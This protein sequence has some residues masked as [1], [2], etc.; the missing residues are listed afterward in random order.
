MK[1]LGVPARQTPDFIDDAAIPKGPPVP[2]PL[3][4]EIR[5][6]VQHTVPVVTED[7]NFS[8][9]I[10]APGYQPQVLQFP[11]GVPS[12]IEDALEATERRLQNPL[13]FC[14]RLIAVRPQPFHTCAAAILAPDWSSYAALSL[15]CLDLRDMVPGGKGPIF[16][17]YVTRP[18]SVEELRR[19]AGALGTRPAAIYVG[20]DAT[21]L[22][23][24]E[25]V[26]LA[27][28]SLVTFMSSESC[29]NYANDL[30][31]RLQF[32]RIWD[33]PAQFPK[34]A[35]GQTALL[36]LHRSGRYVFKTR[37]ANETPDEALARFVGVDR[38]S[39][40]LHTPR[41]QVLAGL[42]YRGVDIRG[43]IAID[44][45]RED[46][47]YIV[48]LD[49]RQIGE[50]VQ[51]ITLDRPY[52]L[53]ADLSRY[54]AKRP[55]PAWRVKVVGGRRRRNR[56]EVQGHDTLVFGFE[57]VTPDSDASSSPFDPTTDDENG[58]DNESEEEGTEQ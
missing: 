9:W 48:F 40:A 47:Y 21:P 56:I 54:I 19:E 23:R 13:P 29:P 39:V 36:L 41:D 55:P 52:I 3:Y 5:N 24:D 49:L 42:H 16:T 31:Y 6:H 38:A 45:V 22:Q 8:I 30:Q 32:P 33:L 20:T 28:G 57:Y 26:V 14:D 17:A 2:R 18:T 58:D 35:P 12:D 1:Q 7:V 4:V 34:Q 37:A 46:P 43:V 44:E 50:G 10:A 27:S 25:S 53:L 15:L 51:F 11:L